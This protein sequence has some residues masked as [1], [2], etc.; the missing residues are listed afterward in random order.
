M[1]TAAMK[2]RIEF[3][4]AAGRAFCNLEK[5]VQIQLQTDIN[6]LAS[7]P[8]PPGCKKLKGSPEM[9]RIRSGNYRVIYEI[10]DNKLV[11]L[12]VDVGHRKDIY[13]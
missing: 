13:N 10:H 7:Q 9:W 11:V 4:K 6:Q 8:R 1:R 3:T 5:A 2:Y 12:V